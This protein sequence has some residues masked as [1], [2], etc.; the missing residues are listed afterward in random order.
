MATTDLPIL[1]AAYEAASDLGLRLDGEVLIDAAGEPW[2]MHEFSAVV[3]ARLGY[4]PDQPRADNGQ[5]GEGSGGGGSSTPEHVSEVVAQSSSPLTVAASTTYQYDD[6]ALNV[7]AALRGG[8]SSY[9]DSNWEAQGG[10]SGD[11]IAGLDAAARETPLQ[12][13]VTVYRGASMTG[14]QLDALEAAGG[15]SDQAFQSTTLTE[16][17]A[18]G[19]ASA[20]ARQSGDTGAS[21]VLFRMN[22]REGT[23]AFQGAFGS[24]EIV[25]D[26]GTSWSV[27]SVDRTGEH[28]VVTVDQA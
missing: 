1:A 11:L 4:N 28:P 12:S 19:Y 6:T 27:T 3:A 25:L 9:T 15:F 13:D 18:V 8:E 7:N 26:R 5:F 17:I 23:G 14:A 22:A 20:R 16:R 24:N 10:S 21:V 2:T